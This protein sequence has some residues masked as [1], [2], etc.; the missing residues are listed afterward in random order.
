MSGP[1]ARALMVAPLGNPTQATIVDKLA[2]EGS[3]TVS[4]LTRSAL[5][6]RQGLG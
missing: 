2:R 5:I 6:S 1:E 3:L 4:D